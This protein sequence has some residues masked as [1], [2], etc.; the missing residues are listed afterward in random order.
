MHSNKGKK[1]TG[2]C[3]NSQNF[4]KL[5][6]LKT[7]ICFVF[8]IKK[9]M[10]KYNEQLLNHINVHLHD[11]VHVQFEIVKN[12]SCLYFLFRFTPSALRKTF[13]LFNLFVNIC[14]LFRED[15]GSLLSCKLG[16]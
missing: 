15:E 3:Q 8:Y 10:S 2:E 13:F 5:N 11:H 1:Y 4:L 16:K 7:F 9:R 14:V 12:V 6:F